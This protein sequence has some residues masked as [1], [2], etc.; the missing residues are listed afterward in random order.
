MM[1]FANPQY[2]WLFLVYIPIMLWYI[3]KQRV[4][5]PTLKVSTLLPFDKVGTSWTAYLRHVSFVMRLR[6]QK[7][8]HLNSFREERA[9]I[10][11]W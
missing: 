4:A 11:V 1:S 6:L 8:W 5:E 3:K 7:M 10:L 9:I 2:L